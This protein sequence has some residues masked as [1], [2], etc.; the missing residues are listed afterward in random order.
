MVAG[1][2]E[3]G[4]ESDCAREFP[5][6]ITDPLL[7]FSFWCASYIYLVKEKLMLLIRDEGCAA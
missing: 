1:R 2:C 6:D 4:M 7:S 5:I 3:K